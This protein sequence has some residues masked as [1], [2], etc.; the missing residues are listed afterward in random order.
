MLWHGIQIADDCGK[1][2][3]IRSVNLQPPKAICADRK[4]SRL[5]MERLTA[6]HDLRQKLLFLEQA[7]LASI[8]HRNSCYPQTLHRPDVPPIQCE[9][10]YRVHNLSLTAY[11][12]T[13]KKTKRMSVL[14]TSFSKRFGIK[15]KENKRQ[16]MY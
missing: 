2:C 10:F 15:I 9:L 12:K 5:T 1:N 8:S 14:S 7:L 13:V 16:Y 6:C 3:V 4:Y 11:L